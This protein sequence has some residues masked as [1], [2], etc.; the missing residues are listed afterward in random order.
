V[1]RGIPAGRIAGTATALVLAA[2]LTAG[3][4]SGGSKPQH[5]A[6]STGS[7]TGP[8]AVATLAPVAATAAVQPNDP[9][10]TSA[11][12][13]PGEDSVYPDVGDPGVD[14][15]HYSI[16]L[17]WTPDDRTLQADT[18]IV[19]RST[20]AADH[21]QLDFEQSLQVDKVTLDGASVPFQHTGKDLVVQGSFTKDQRY[22]LDVRYHGTPV[23]A[24]APTTRQDLSTLG[25]TITGDG[26]VWTMQ[27]PYGAYTWYPVNDQ[28][29]DKA[30]YDI[31]I[32]TP[33]PWSGIANG[34]ETDSATVKG[35]TT[36]SW[37]LDQPAASYLVTVAIGNYQK[38]TN[39]SA[40]GMT[41]TYWIA[42][43][44]GG[45]HVGGVD[46]SGGSE[47]L[48]KQVHLAAGALDWVESKLGPYP[49]KS[50]GFLLV[51]STS[52]ME[53]QTMI[54]LGAHDFDV[55]GPVL[56]HEL[57]HQWYGDDVTPNDWRDVWMN[58]GMAMYLQFMWE[59][60]QD[61]KT[62]A[63]RLQPVIGQEAALRA[64]DGPP[65]NYDPSK[66]AE[67]NVYYG[68]ALMYQG[69]R[70]KIGDAKFFQ[71]IKDW[72]AAH[73]H[74][75]QSRDTFVP[76]LAQHSGVPESYFDHWLYD[77]TSPQLTLQ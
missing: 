54:T 36:T 56:V 74:S 63:Q 61:G 44:A 18:A 13:T 70:Q 2:A 38:T 28:P 31:T 57:V 43:G 14:A 64:A 1:T 60:E 58:E 33:A 65:G 42:R 75:T 52:G 46:S 26:Q 66:F 62:I 77:T 4:D 47:G 53:T 71:L 20:V 5:P 48:A 11:L 45:E 30:F 10:L 23:P 27:E 19:F 73:P 32:T 69:L 8:G 67:S 34:E 24:A 55:A 9:S 29:S 35:L 22:L 6:V 76:W 16:N 15:L 7:G 50:L 17:A 37:H 59:A 39:T 25:W 72:P 68:P 12:S 3:C 51:D 21:V 41:I 40:D 49:F